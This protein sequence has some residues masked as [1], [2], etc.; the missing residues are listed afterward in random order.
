MITN[1]ER[2][3]LAKAYVALSNSHQ[4]GLIIGLFANDAQYS[5][6][7][8]GSYSGPGAIQKMMS[9]FFNQ[10]PDVFWH[11]DEFKHS[12]HNCV[13]FRFELTAT[14]KATGQRIERVGNEEIE[15]NSD[16]LIA[17]LEVT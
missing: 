7:N 16:G 6:S 17:R 5:S 15:F 9:Q 12:G 10:Y 8:V 4:L 14:N 11:T 2:I 3:E 13:Q 1:L